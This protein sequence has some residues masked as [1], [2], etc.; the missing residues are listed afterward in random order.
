MHAYTELRINVT[1]C[2]G[3]I[4]LRFPARTSSRAGSLAGQRNGI[5]PATRTRRAHAGFRPAR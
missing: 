3:Q 5:W 4:P 1:L 2:K